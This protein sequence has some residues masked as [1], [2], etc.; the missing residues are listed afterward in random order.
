MSEASQHD[1]SFAEPLVICN[2]KNPDNPT[3]MY[4]CFRCIDDELL[5][6]LL[7]MVAENKVKVFSAPVIPNSITDWCQKLA[8]LFACLTLPSFATIEACY[9]CCHRLVC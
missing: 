4:G 1:S 3:G 6:R 5:A 9:K 7:S 8:R 2:Y